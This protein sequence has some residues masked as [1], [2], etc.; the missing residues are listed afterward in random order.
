MGRK[1]KERIKKEYDI[2]IQEKIMLGFYE[3]YLWNDN[4]DT[5]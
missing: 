3:E 4:N 1:A 2:E 5:K